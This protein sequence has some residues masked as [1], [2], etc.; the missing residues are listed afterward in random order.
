[1]SGY[2]GTVFVE[3]LTR[4]A[5][6]KSCNSRPFPGTL[7]T[8]LVKDLGQDRFA[9]IIFELQNFCGDLDQERVKDAFVPSE[10]DVRNLVFIETKATLQYVVSLRYQLH[11]AVFDTCI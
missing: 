10:E 2:V 6:V 5:S 4:D 8:S 3:D 9:V 11:V 7:L 1:M